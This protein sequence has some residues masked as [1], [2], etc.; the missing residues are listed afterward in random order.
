MFRWKDVNDNANDHGLAI[1][2]VSITAWPED[3][4][5]PVELSAFTAV[6]GDGHVTLHWATESE[7]NNMQFDILRAPEQQGE[8]VL[9]GS[10]E[11]QFNTN[12][13]TEY[14]FTDDNVVNGTT[15]WYKLEDVDING[16]RTEHGPISATPGL[17]EDVVADQFKLLQ[18]YPNPFNPVT[19]LQ[20]YV[21]GNAGATSSVKVE[22]YN[23][24]GQKVITLF[25]GN[26]A[27]GLHPLTW[28]GDSDRGAAVAGGIYFA[29]L[30]AGTF[31]DH[32]KLALLK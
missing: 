11:G 30:R 32:I 14:T 25:D 7:I 12:Q 16:L 31:Q 17:P 4:G 19:T 21:P 3:N 10:R 8:Y 15:Y 24:L 22:I 29:I 28:N 27:A 6:A 13:R 18:N 9:I 26:L 5:L 1:D 2:N 23:L 20:V